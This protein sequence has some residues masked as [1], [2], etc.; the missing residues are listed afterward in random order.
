MNI[1]TDNYKMEKY[2]YEDL[3]EDNDCND[4]SDLSQK[5][6]LDM[7]KMNGSEMSE[8]NFKYINNNSSS[9]KKLSNN[10][11]NNLK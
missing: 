6:I 7:E 9:T 1:E 5:F 10:L 4:Y 2:S 3:E 8:N 11:E